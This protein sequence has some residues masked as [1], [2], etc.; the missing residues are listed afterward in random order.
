MS[1]G[2]DKFED[3]VRLL[4]LE[5]VCTERFSLCSCLYH[6]ADLIECD[7]IQSIFP[8]FNQRYAYII[9]SNISSLHGNGF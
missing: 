2:I 6:F 1:F 4:K 3:R 5:I 8:Q 9:E 7:E